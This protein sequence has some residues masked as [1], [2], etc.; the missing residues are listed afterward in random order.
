MPP[1][2]FKRGDGGLPL[3]TDMDVGDFECEDRI[4]EDLVESEHFNVPEMADGLEACQEEIAFA[5][6][7][8]SEIEASLE[9]LRGRPEESAEARE[10]S[11]ALVDKWRRR[12]G[13]ALARRE[14]LLEKLPFRF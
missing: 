9:F 10:S 14:A 11:E 8:I 7:R 5:E 3:V 13:N 1:S 12:L 4:N 6:Q 2:P